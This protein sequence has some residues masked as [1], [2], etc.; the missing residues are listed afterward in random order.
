MM[1]RVGRWAGRGG[2]GGGI[3]NS[4]ICTSYQI[5]TP[6]TYIAHARRISRSSSF[7]E[8]TSRTTTTPETFTD[9][10]QLTFRSTLRRRCG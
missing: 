5:L 1:A 3:L 6:K 2:A 7:G 9:I 10:V 8:R 4:F